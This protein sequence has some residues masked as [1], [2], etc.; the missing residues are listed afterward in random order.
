MSFNPVSA[1]KYVVK[2]LMMECSRIGVERLL[3]H[4]GMPLPAHDDHGWFHLQIRGTTVD[5]L[6]A[7]AFRPP[8]CQVAATYVEQLRVTMTSCSVLRSLW[9]FE[10]HWPRSELKHAFQSHITMPYQKWLQ[11]CPVS[12]L[13]HHATAVNAVRFVWFCDAS[14]GCRGAFLE[15][16]VVGCRGAFLE[17]KF[18]PLRYEESRN[19]GMDVSAVLL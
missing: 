8:V 12:V 14:F 17:S 2:T 18:K 6:L 5:F 10:S 19:R 11:S 1:P 9:F 16:P 7:A 15:M 13:W 3:L 4:K